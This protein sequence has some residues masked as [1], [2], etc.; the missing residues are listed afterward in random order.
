MLL[1]ELVTARIAMM[2]RNIAV[3][4][5]DWRAELREGNSRGLVRVAAS[6]YRQVLPAASPEDCCEFRTQAKASGM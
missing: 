2:E 4:Q 1:V 5:S 3:K 6:V